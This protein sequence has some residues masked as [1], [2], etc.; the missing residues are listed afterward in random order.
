MYL[1]PALPSFD[2]KG[3]NTNNQ[4][5]TFTSKAIK[6]NSTSIAADPQRHKTTGNDFSG[7]ILPQA[8]TKTLESFPLSLMKSTL[9]VT[10]RFLTSSK[11]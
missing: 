1:P 2:G 9:H 8:Q 3:G 6:L 5:E 7:S 4:R 10:I 11:D